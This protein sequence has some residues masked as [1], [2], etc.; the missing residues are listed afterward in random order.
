[1]EGQILQDIDR[2]RQALV[3][4]R[5]HWY[6]QRR[7]AALEQMTWLLQKL[8]TIKADMEQLHRS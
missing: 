8:E 7:T 5:M 1:M 6:D 3:E 4:A 2:A